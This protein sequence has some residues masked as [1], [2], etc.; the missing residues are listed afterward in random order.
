[1][2]LSGKKKYSFESETWDKSK[3]S[4]KFYLDGSETGKWKVRMRV[5]FSIILSK[6][7]E[8]FFDCASL[9]MCKKLYSRK[10]EKQ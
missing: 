10:K 9:Q 7:K 2:P 4:A 5:K 6:I 3:T 8:R 1:M